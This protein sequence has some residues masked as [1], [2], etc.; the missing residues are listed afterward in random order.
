MEAVEGGEK[1]GTNSAAT[2]MDRDESSDGASSV[3]GQIL[4]TAADAS[5][6]RCRIICNGCLVIYCLNMAATVKGK[7]QQG[8]MARQELLQRQK[9]TAL[10]GAKFN[11]LD[12]AA[13]REL[14]PSCDCLLRN[15]LLV[16]LE[17]AC[18][19][20]LDPERRDAAA[21]ASAGKE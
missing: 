4:Y 11:G 3:A 7:L 8:E 14:L 21:A 17:K 13:L 12:G 20:E 9:L 16:L 15:I 18:R 6:S 1:D 19:P 5:L 2:E 10:P